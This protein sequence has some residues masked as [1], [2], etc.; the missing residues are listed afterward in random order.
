MYKALIADSNISDRQRLCQMFRN[1]PE[2]YEITQAESGKD[3]LDLASRMHPELVIASSEI[4]VSDG[5]RFIEQLHELSTYSAVVVAGYEEERMLE[6]SLVSS[7]DGYITKP[8][9]QEQLDGVLQRSQNALITNSQKKRHLEWVLKQR[10]KQC[11]SAELSFLANW[12]EGHYS[13]QEAALSLKRLGIELPKQYGLILIYLTCDEGRINAGAGWDSQLL[14]YA[15]ENI[16]WEMLTDF[17]PTAFSSNCGDLVIIS[18][19]DPHNKWNLICDRLEST[20][21]TYLPVYASVAYGIG[22]DVD[23]MPA[24]YEQTVEQLHAS[25]KCSPVVL[26]AQSMIEKAYQDVDLSLIMVAKALRVSPQYL[27]RIFRTGTGTTFINYVTRVRIRKAIEL[28][29]QYDLKIYEIAEAVGY[30]SPHYF[31]SAFKK[32]LDISPLEYRKQRYMHK[33]RH[34]VSKEKVL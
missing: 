28:L 14:Y 4:A 32:T 34:K 30:S 13:K 3:A 33:Y 17:V 8:F 20:L 27:S 12:M 19:R 29:T 15:A 5:F 26:S 6:D 9:E 11:Q 10:E 21:E 18:S 31:S 25:V 22:I 23:M 7:V 1:Y 2:G 24:V 16:A